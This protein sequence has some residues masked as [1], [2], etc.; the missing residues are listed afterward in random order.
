MKQ[1]SWDY[2]EAGQHF[3]S[4]PRTLQSHQLQGS[5]R[6][7][8]RSW[9]YQERW[10]TFPLSVKD[11]TIPSTSRKQNETTKLELSRTPQ[12]QESKRMN[13][14]AGI[15]RS[16]R[17]FPPS[18]NNTTISLTSRNQRRKQPS[19]NYQQARQH[20]FCRSGLLQPL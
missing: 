6:I 13:N 14:V 5:K 16:W 20:F 15:P 9:N 2:Q 1:H 8:Q 17:T 4:Q 18:V 10:R 7:K 11:T 12:L 19:W 3:L